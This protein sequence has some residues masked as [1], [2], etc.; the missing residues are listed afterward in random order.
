MTAMTEVA[1]GAPD[2]GSVFEA[3]RRDLFALA[4]RITGSASDAD[5]VVQEAFARALERPPADRSLPWKPWLVRVAANL[6]RD[7]LRRRRRRGYR[8]PW[9]PEPIEE[10]ELAEPSHEPPSTEGRYALLESVSYAFLVA[11]E[12]L[13][14]TQRAV[15]VL[16]DVLEYTARETAEALDLS[17]AN[18][19][20]TLHR[21]R[22]ALAAYDAQR[23]DCDRELSSRTEATLARFLGCLATGDVAGL[24]SLLA[25]GVVAVNDGGG[26]YAAAR[27]PVVGRNKVARFHA[28][29]GRGAPSRFAVRLVNGLPAFVGEYDETRPHFA[30]RFVM[31]PI[32]DRSGRIRAIHTLVAPAKLRRI[33][34][35]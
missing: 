30:P 12:A 17:E 11:L 31:I 22:R 29:L 2:L 5:D 3:H 34:A 13:T 23:A 27:V 24:E 18:S 33:R 20:T 28:S 26:V 15:L 6:A 32:L 35:V 4:Y 25:D 1:A 9:L 10:I 19:R 14:P 8:G 7:E 16:C 21:A